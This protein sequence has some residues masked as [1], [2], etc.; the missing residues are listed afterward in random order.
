MFAVHA[1]QVV[2][3]EFWEIPWVDWSIE[4]HVAAVVSTN[5]NSR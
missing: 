1:P 4:S 5:E 3:S 2:I